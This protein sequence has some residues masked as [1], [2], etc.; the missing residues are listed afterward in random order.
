MLNKINLFGVQM[1]IEKN[2]P[3]IEAINNRLSC[4][5]FKQKPVPKDALKKIIDAGNQAPFT[6]ITRCQPWRFVIVENPVFRQEL[7]DTTF[8]IWKKSMENIKEAAPE[9][10]NT[11]MELYES[12]DDPKDLVYYSAP[13]IVFI[14]GPKRNSICCSLACENM[15]IA[16][17]SL[18]LGSCYVGFGSMVTGNEEIVKKLELTKDEKIYGPILLGYPKD[19]SD[20]KVA[21]GLAHLAPNKKE[22]KIKWI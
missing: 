22:P 4:R 3:V 19:I 11:A 12:L 21:K 5:D 1:S 9:I 10:Y 15:M 16:A 2:N 8:P 7:I 6:S 17:T 13:A 14:I 20:S 18:G